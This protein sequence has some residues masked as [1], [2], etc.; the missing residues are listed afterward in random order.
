MY[1]LQ[2]FAKDIIAFAVVLAVTATLAMA[3]YRIFKWVWIG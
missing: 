1:E 3:A 2:E